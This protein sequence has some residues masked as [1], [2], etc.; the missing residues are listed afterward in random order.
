MGIGDEQ[1][2]A[3]GKQ[4]S[5]GEVQR[6]VLSRHIVASMA[7]PTRSGDGPDHTIRGDPP[8]PVV[9]RVRDIDRSIGTNHKPLRA[10]QAGGDGRS[11]VTQV[12]A[13]HSLSGPGEGRDDPGDAVHPA[14]PVVLGV[15]DEQ[16]A[17]GA[18]GDR[19]GLVE[20]DLHRGQPVPEAWLV[21][22]L[23]PTVRRI[24]VAGSMRRTREPY[25]SAMCSAP[26]ASRANPLG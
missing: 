18:E 26:L 24:P 7:R 2:P 25:V 23:P 3:G 5:A 14:D 8:D 6:R 16:V 11:A 1:G 21:V 22:A 9:A 19:A 17:R 15:G 13:V 4:K 20:I 10:G 12:P